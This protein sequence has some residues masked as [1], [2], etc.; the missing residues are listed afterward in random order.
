MRLVSL[1]LAGALIM[2][3]AMAESAQTFG[4][5]KCSQ[6]VAC[7]D[8]GGAASDTYAAAGNACVKEGFGYSS[9]SGYFDTTAGLDPNSCLTSIPGT[10]PKGAG[11]QLIPVC[12]VI[13]L[14]TNTCVFRCDLN[15]Y[16]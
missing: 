6:P 2:T 4:S 5:Y 3:P 12:C 11:A 15:T 10:F 13:K 9:P 14:N 8:A 16:Q 7:A 1:V